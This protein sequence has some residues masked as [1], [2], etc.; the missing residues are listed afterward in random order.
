MRL[1]ELIAEG[2]REVEQKYVAAGADPQTVKKA[3]DQFRDLV[4]RNQVQGQERNIDWWGKT[5]AF[6]EFANFV[7]Q[8]AATPTRTEIKRKRSVGRAI[9]LIEDENWLIV[10]PLDKDASCFYGRNS[11]WCTAMPNQSYYENY[12]YN[13][14]ITLIY[15]INKQT[16]AKWAIAG[17]RDLDQ[18]EMFD[19][20][21]TSISASEFKR[22]TGL[23]PIEIS[24]IALKKH[25]PEL[26]QTREEFKSKDDE[27]SA[28]MYEFY[29]NVRRNSKIE[30]LLEYLKNAKQSYEYIQELGES[31]QDVDAISKTI[32]ANAAKYSWSVIRYIKNPA[33]AVLE[34]AL[35]DENRNA[36]EYIVDNLGI[37]L[38]DRMVASYLTTEGA[39]LREAI[40]DLRSFNIDISEQ[41]VERT[42]K[43][44]IDNTYYYLRHGYIVPDKYQL[45]FIENTQW[46]L[47]RDAFRV[48]SDSS[49]AVKEKL[50]EYYPEA[51][52]E[53]NNTTESMRIYAYAKNPYYLR[54]QTWNGYFPSAKEQAALD[55][56]GFDPE[57]I[58][59]YV[60]YAKRELQSNIDYQEREIQ[61][62]QNKI[63]R[64]QKF[65]IELEN[66]INDKDA[67]WR[68]KPDVSAENL[69]NL[70]H[71][72]REKSKSK[73][74]RLTKEIE[75]SKQIIAGIQ[76]KYNRLIDGEKKIG[77]INLD[78]DKID[79]GPAADA[80]DEWY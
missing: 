76:Q 47:D 6:D 68:K 9:T 66:E 59:S 39:S 30:Q 45:D 63:D 35:Y 79:Y 28:L 56:G 22:E 57:N 69:I 42:L 34:Q 19:Q 31:G 15:C 65:I 21:D 7:Q 3:L 60:D 80:D 58:K 18:I 14:E 72:Y 38:T 52:D 20:Q 62:Y 40:L 36:L 74:D 61:E 50:V 70:L 46:G 75:D 55:K 5:T 49:D 23:D 2:Y 78:P 54:R 25:E 8:K 33:P 24:A 43:H 1:M 29:D 16:G 11:A 32:Q 13:R 17:H 26:N 44:N 48:F 73:I 67:E 4:N 37:K 51:M 12:F 27:L 53:F 71:D 10:I 64:D 77:Y 41:V